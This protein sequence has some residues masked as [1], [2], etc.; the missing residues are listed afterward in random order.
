M[1]GAVLTGQNT[2]EIAERDAP[3]CGASDVILAVEVCGVCRTDRKMFNV[4]Q[5]DLTLPRIPGHEIVGRVVELGASVTSVRPGD[6][7]QVSPG[8]FC[9]VCDYCRSGTDQLCDEMKIIG[10]HLDGGF[11]ELLH[12]PGK[13]EEPPVLNKIPKHLDSKSAA[14][15]E[16]LACCLNLQK[17]MDIEAK[18][19]IIFGAGP[20]GILNAQL[21]H[22]LGA[23]QIV[24]VEPME[25]RRSLA[26]RFSD[27]QLDFDRHL[28]QNIAEFTRGRG[29]DVVLPCCPSSEPFLIGLE[30]AAKRG[31]LGFFSGLTDSTGITSSNLNLIHYKELTVTGS[32][33]CSLSDNHQALELLASGRVSVLD[34]PSL[35]VSWHDLRETLSHLAPYE[36]VFTYFIP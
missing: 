11:A 6:R 27:C 26:A 13:G 17:R 8:V 15:A 3:H 28:T 5:R 10:F 36:H 35:D 22:T 19:V 33:G 1:R 12:V 23:K 16:P 32:Y 2:L 18:T 21:A 31:Q 25:R 34:L 4:G 29:A 24:I 14:L 30:I 20:L 7:V 9:G